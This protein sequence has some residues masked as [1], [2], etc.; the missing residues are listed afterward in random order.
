MNRYNVQQILIDS[1]GAAVGK[2]ESVTRRHLLAAGAATLAATAIGSAVAATPAS[3]DVKPWD[4][5]FDVI[6]IGFG[7]SGGAAAYEAL[8]AGA[9]V[10]VLDRGSAAANESHGSGFYLGGGTALQRALRVEDTPEEMEKYLLAT[11]G[12]EP[13]RE[14]IKLYVERSIAHFEWLVQIKMPFNERLSLETDDPYQHAGGLGYSGDEQSY[15]FRELCKPAPRGHGPAEI[16]GIWLQKRLL[17]LTRDSSVQQ[18]AADAQQLVLGAGGEVQGVTAVID[19]KLL[20]FRARRGV[21]LATGGFANNREMVALHSPRN[22]NCVPIDVGANDGWGIRAAQAIGAAVKRMDA[23][24]PFWSLYPPYSRKQGILVNAQG[25]R[26]V[27]EDSYYGRVS[28]ALMREQ[29]GVAHLIVDADALGVRPAWMEKVLGGRNEV[30]A[31]AATLAELEKAL[32][33][34]A[35]ALQQTVGNYNRYAAQGDDPFFHKSK[36]HLRPLAKSPFTAI[37]ASINDTYIPFFTLGGLST[38]AKTEVLDVNNNPIP[39]L[40]AVGRVASGIP[41]SNYFSSGL[42]L[43]EGTVFGRV[44][45]ITAAANRG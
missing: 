36:D 28:D 34:P 9:K 42:S 45:G 19:G 13:D 10:L 31:Q 12:P 29:G 44:A 21:I 37:K 18:L 5:E 32:K 14:K 33:I 27:E 16:G 24:A 26:F 20:A 25:Q 22:L 15:P 17:E 39:H 1:D 6:V 3:V 8:R 38:S 40:Y 41:A 2:N 4:R 35:P 7:V 23:I 43:G 30:A 11:N